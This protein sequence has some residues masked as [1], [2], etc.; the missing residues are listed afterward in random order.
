MGSCSAACGTCPETD[1]KEVTNMEKFEED[2]N[3]TQHIGKRRTANKVMIKSKKSNDPATKPLLHTNPSDTSTTPGNITADGGLD[4]M[5]GIN[6]LDPA[7]RQMIAGMN[8]QTPITPAGTVPIQ[9][10]DSNQSEQYES[11][12]PAINTVDEFAAISPM[13]PMD[14]IAVNG[15][16]PVTNPVS[17]MITEH[18][19]DTSVHTIPIAEMSPDPGLSPGPAMEID[20]IT[21]SPLPTTDADESE[22]SLDSAQKREIERLK[23]QQIEQQ[24]A[25]RM[26]PNVA[27]THSGVRSKPKSFQKGRSMYR[28]GTVT[29]WADQQIAN[30]YNEMSRELEML[31]KQHTDSQNQLQLQHLVQDPS[32]S[33]SGL[34][35]QF[36]PYAQ[37]ELPVVD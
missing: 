8:F 30:H 3:R 10:T 4:M 14:P 23:Q 13:D 25:M 34:G 1:D 6:S 29:E 11:G 20:T 28:P 33:G 32:V 19:Q 16:E 9:A 5:V 35:Y 24:E 7:T 21:E 31:T 2:A 26:N 37:P 22:S 18:G 17:S 27:T 12:F 36:D 15:P